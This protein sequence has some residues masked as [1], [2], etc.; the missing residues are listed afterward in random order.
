MLNKTLGFMNPGAFLS[1]F[2]IALVI[3]GAGCTFFLLNLT[4][5]KSHINFSGNHEY[6][7]LGPTTGPVFP[8]D[9]MSECNFRES[10]IQ[11]LKP[12]FLEAYSNHSPRGTMNKKEFQ[13]K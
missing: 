2:P 5:V 12:M 7:I 3:Y 9:Q 1:N 10:M 8:M 6:I 11:D 13:N 4:R